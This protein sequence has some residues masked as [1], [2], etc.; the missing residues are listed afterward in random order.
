MRIRIGRPARLSSTS[1]IHIAAIR[2]LAVD[3]I[4]A[5]SGRAGVNKVR[6]LIIHTCSGVDIVAIGKA[7]ILKVLESVEV[8]CGPGA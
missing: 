5:D 3:S 7:R 6:A 1:L 4:P 8:R 2:R